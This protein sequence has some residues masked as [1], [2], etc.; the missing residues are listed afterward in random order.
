MENEKMYTLEEV[1]DKVRAA[2]EHRAT[3]MALMYLE[4]KKAGVQNAEQITRAAISKTGEMHGKAM[5]AA[6]Q[7]PDDIRQFNDYFMT[8]STKATFGVDVQKNL[9]DELKLEFGYCAL[10]EGWKKLGVDDETLELLCDMAMDGD[11]GIARGMGYDFEL[12]DTIAKRDCK[13]CQIRF[14]SKK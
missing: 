12:K 6:I 14:F 5:R 8:P 13:N 10:V 1:R 4:M 9:P 2:I 3:W 11:R 7:N